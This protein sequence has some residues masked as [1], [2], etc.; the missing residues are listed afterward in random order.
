MKSVYKCSK[1]SANFF[2][3]QQKLPKHFNNKEVSRKF[4]IFNF[5]EIFGCFF[6]FWFCSMN[7]KTSFVKKN[8]ISG[9][10]IFRDNERRE[11]KIVRTAKRKKDHQ[12]NT[13]YKHE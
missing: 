6:K 4:S 1:L 11:L 10:T 2:Q 5:S 7:Y 9:R 8:R 12:K 13:L 3:F